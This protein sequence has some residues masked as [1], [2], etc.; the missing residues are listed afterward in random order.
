MHLPEALE[1]AACTA[2]VHAKVPLGHETLSPAP[3]IGP[4]LALLCVAALVAHG[5]RGLLLTRAWLSLDNIDVLS[6]LFA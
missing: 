5:L 3:L 6:P 2:S 4:P 1:R